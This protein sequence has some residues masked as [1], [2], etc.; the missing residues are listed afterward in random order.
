MEGAPLVVWGQ[1]EGDARRHYHGH[2]VC[3]QHRAPS[4]SPKAAPCLTVVPARAAA[5]LFGR[6]KQVRQELAAAMAP[7]E[8]GHPE[9]PGGGPGAAA[10]PPAHA[11][12]SFHLP[13]HTGFPSQVLNLT[14]YKFFPKSPEL[15]ILA[16]Y[17]L[18]SHEWHSWWK[19]GSRRTFRKG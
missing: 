3:S 18:I 6:L 17:P 1:E 13:E 12:E 2:A 16:I 19:G 9:R 8:V 15:I 7:R 10:A 5:L 14:M 4:A 11:P